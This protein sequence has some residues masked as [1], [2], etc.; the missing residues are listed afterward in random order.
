MLMPSL[1]PLPRQALEVVRPPSHHLHAFLKEF[2]AHVN[3]ANRTAR[4]GRCASWASMASGLNKPDSL[5][6]RRGGRAKAVAD[7]LLLACS[8][9]AGAPHLSCL[10]TWPRRGVRMLGKQYLP[11]PVSIRSSSSSADC[12]RAEGDGMRLAHLH[13]R[14]RNRPGLFGE[15]DLGPLHMPELEGAAKNMHQQ[16]ERRS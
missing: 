4:A 14:C 6:K 2:A 11:S 7:K 13:L 8:Q 5:R 10:P 15:V 1:R 9:G 16:Q 3:A 12:L